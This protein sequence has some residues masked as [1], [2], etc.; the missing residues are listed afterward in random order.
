MALVDVPSIV[1][2]PSFPANYYNTNNAGSNTD[3]STADERV[4]YMFICPIAGDIE[5]I[6]FLQGPLTSAEDVHF[7]LQDV[8]SKFKPDGTEDQ[9][10]VLASGSMTANTMT[11]T[12]PLTSDG[13]GTGTRRTVAKGDKLALVAKFNSFVSGDVDFTTGVL[14]TG[15][16]GV[17]PN[18][19]IS[20][21][22]GSTW[23]FQDRLPNMAIEYVT[24]GITY[25]QYCFPFISSAASASFNTGTTPDEMGMKFQVPFKGRCKG[26]FFQGAT[27]LVQ[28]SIEN[29]AKTI[30]AGPATTQED[31]SNAQK[32][33]YEWPTPV[34]LTVD[35]DYYLV[36][37]PTS[38]TSRTHRY[39]DLSA[40]TFREAM[41]HG[42]NSS[43]NTRTD[44]G[45]WT[46]TT[47]R[48]VPFGLVFDQLDDGAGGAP[49]DVSQTKIQMA[50][51]HGPIPVY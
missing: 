10:V 36:W 35:T 21:N 20:T 49:A 39:Y 13:T 28:L 50:G 41:P 51:D 43:Y 18:T 22:A 45:A 9:F 27:D 30:Q 48:F 37:E 40:A 38:V 33:Y 3:I 7:S 25:I 16:M 31:T 26:A 47:T 34:T 19:A 46:E 42:L 1:E 8:D 12:G 29:A 15:G 14:A 32:R 2:W 4:A 5:Q 11:A 6:H 24:D 23:T 44:N 17:I